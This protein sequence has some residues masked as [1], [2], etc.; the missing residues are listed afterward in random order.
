MHSLSII[1]PAFNEEDR[2]PA[3]LAALQQLHE[4][5]SLPFLPREIFVVDD[6]S[7]DRTF[8]IAQEMSGKWPQLRVLALAKNQGKGAAVKEALLKAQSEW[9]LVADADMATPWQEIDKLAQYTEKADLI[10]GSRALPTS[11]IGIHQPWLRQTMGKIFN[12]IT[13]LCTGLS[14]R[15]TQCGFKLLRNDEVFRK[16]ILP[17][18]KIKR[19]AWDVELILFMEKFNQKIIE[20]PVEWN[21]QE[22]SRVRLLADS[23]E[24]FFSLLRV[25]INFK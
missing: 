20:V 12:K 17:N 4:S 13:R 10:M 8:Q 16:N 24:M 14:Y 9:I 23:L 15:D 25:S 22:S 2:L 11:H 1:I 3:T 19:F 21:H 7:H 5:N 18:M 6:G